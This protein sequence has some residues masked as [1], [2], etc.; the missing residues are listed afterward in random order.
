M[1]QERS[2][3]PIYQ[4]INSQSNFFRSRNQ[5]PFIQTNNSNYFNSEN[6]YPNN[7]NF[8][9]SYSTYNEKNMS[10]NNNMNNLDH[11]LFKS[12]EFPL[13]RLN[14]YE[15]LKNEE[16]NR[17]KALMDNTQ[18]Q[19]SLSNNFRNGSYGNFVNNFSRSMSFNNLNN[20]NE[21]LDMENQYIT[22][23]L[24]NESLTRNLR[25]LS[26]N[27]NRNFFNTMNLSNNNYYDA[28]LFEENTFNNSN[29][30]NNNNN[31]DGRR[32]NNLSVINELT[33]ENQYNSNPNVRNADINIS[34]DNYELT[35]D[36]KRANQQIYANELQRQMYENEQRK[37][38]ELLKKKLEDEKDEER[39]RRENE[40]LRR[41]AEEERNLTKRNAI[42]TKIIKK[43]EEKKEENNKYKDHEL[44]YLK[45]LDLQSR[46]NLSNELEK[47]RKAI[48]EE[49][50]SLSREIN[51]LKNETEIANKDRKKTLQK[52]DLLK[53]NLSRQKIEDEIRK[54][55][56]YDIIIN[57]NYPIYNYN[58]RKTFFDFQPENLINK[59]A[60]QKF[61]G[62]FITNSRLMNYEENI[63][64]NEKKFKYNIK[65]EDVVL[66]DIKS[67]LQYKD[68]GIKN[69]NNKR[70]IEEDNNEVRNI[71]NKSIDKLRQIKDYEKG[72][73]NYLFRNPKDYKVDINFNDLDNF[74]DEY[75]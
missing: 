27:P 3:S 33:N 53:E 58:Q 45:Q 31:Y 25:P 69:Y 19:M 4:N 15:N 18:N 26:T 49:T 29:S 64:D 56:V 14:T 17:K 36:Q 50:L 74:E 7:E 43:I 51:Y 57:E 9:N 37:K 40:E 23:N 73:S 75:L 39:L 66:N 24:N 63:N 11:S 47:L 68:S 32:I 10:F 71:L 70:V 54:K 21:N 2:Y 22:Q 20:R 38:M 34:Y 62:G 72:N 30:N 42:E 65:D 44:E 46:L 16:S 13:S 48:N 1:L 52:I 28:S 35:K 12:R 59:K 6:N 5:S 61:E 41:R 55:H 60:N 8:S 67:K